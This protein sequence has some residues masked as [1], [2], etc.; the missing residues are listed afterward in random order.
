MAE[1]ERLKS[2]GLRRET[3]FGRQMLC[4]AERPDTLASMFSQ[5]LQRFSDRPAIVE[6]R[7]ISFAELNK[8]A[9]QI[10]AG[11]HAR[12]IR[13]G[14]RVALLLGNCWEFVASFL[15]CTR[16]GII[17]VPIGIRQQRAELEFLLNDSG[18]EAI[19]FEAALVAIVP[20]ATDVKTLRLTFAVHGVADGA[21][22]FET[23]LQHGTSTPLPE[24][25]QDD[26]AVILYTSGTTGKP[27]GAQLTHLGMIHTVL[28]FARSYG[29]TE[30]DRGL[31]AVPLS[32]VTGLVAVMLTM[33]SVGGCAV[34]MRRD[35]KV[36]EFL[37][38]LSRERITYTLVVP[39]IYTLC[40][41]HPNFDN[42]DLSAWRIGGFGGAPMPVPT[43]EA[44]ALKMPQLE[45]LNAYGATETT[46]P[47][48]VMPR[49][50]WRDNLD[51]VGKAVP[52]GEIKIVDDTGAVVAP[53]EAGELLIA[54]PMVVPGYW[55]R[56]D[57]DASEFID[58]FWRSGDIGS[59][60]ANGFVK[61]F[62][63]KKDMLN[64][65]GF[66][67]FCAEVE[68]VICGLDGVA[69]CA[70]IGRPDPVLGERV[71]AIIVP[72]EIAAVSQQAVRDYCAAR[73]ADY[74]VP[75]I[76][77]LR[78]EPLPRNANGKILKAVLRQ[79]FAT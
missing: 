12:G 30:H 31:V 63:R 75:E 37:D 33:L 25:T 29:L 27:K 41:M 8:L 39:T 40:V 67:V 73:M 52:C 64:R 5:V 78:S 65:G 24:L 7:T 43:I 13:R 28:T 44:L 77:T 51:S 45:L 62:D 54:G 46:S 26:I 59:M 76:V 71:H 16:S 17:V 53:G 34:L 22:A 4:F 74:K 1:T 19:I 32:H 60:D 15:A 35:F 48:T 20:S 68:N 66:K 57:A 2:E 56:P 58:G 21:E 79:L 70:I 18:A 11:L 50:F 36:V 23:L 9:A 14:D 72:H 47:A 55:N 49:A 10:A 38:L 3:H 69:E 61:V 42:H 6:G